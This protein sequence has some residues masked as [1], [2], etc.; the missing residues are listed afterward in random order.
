MKLITDT[1]RHCESI[2]F[3]KVLNLYVK[4]S[5]KYKAVTV[6][7]CFRQHNSVYIHDTYVQYI[8]TSV[9]FVK[10]DIKNILNKLF[11]KKSIS[12]N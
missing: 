9:F 4:R 1:I 2:S 6:I 5:Y 10:K 8:V 3:V 12:K 7:W 11:K